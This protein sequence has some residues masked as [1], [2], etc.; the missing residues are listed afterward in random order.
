MTPKIRVAAP[1]LTLVRAVEDAQALLA[2]FADRARN[3]SG[4]SDP[5]P[6]LLAQCAQLY[7]DTRAATEPYRTLLYD[8]PGMLGPLAEVLHRAPNLIILANGSTA[9]TP[10]LV[11]ADRIMGL[12]LTHQLDRHNESIDLAVVLTAFTA[13]IT[14]L[15]DGLTRTGQRLVVLRPVAL[16]QDADGSGPGP[17]APDLQPARTV[18]VL[19]HPA[20]SFEHAVEGTDLDAFCTRWHEYLDSNRHIITLRHEILLQ[21]P[22]RFAAS[23]GQGLDLA[24]PNGPSVSAPSSNAKTPFPEAS[25]LSPDDQ[26]LPS[27]VELCARLGYAASP[28]RS[29]AAAG[30]PAPDS[31]KPYHRAILVVG[32]PRTGT[33]FAASLLTALGLEVGHERDGK[34]GISSWMFAVE[35][36]KNPY[37]I[38]PVAASRR[39]L[40]WDHLLHPV[41]DVA[42][43][44]PSI[45][46]EN[47]YAP[48]SL[49]FRRY[50]ILRETG[51]DLDLQVDGFA[52]AVLSLLEWSRIIDRLAPGLVFR[53]EDQQDR[54]LTYLRNHELISGIAMPAPA[55]IKTND[56]KAYQGFHYP[57]PAIG[58]ADWAKLDPPTWLGVV[59]Y[60]QRYGYDL[61]SRDEA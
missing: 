18:L 60:C 47:A 10:G 42:T 21:A 36:A 1:P 6:G 19:R 2:E 38:D 24:F 20:S 44:V 7:K 58:A 30:F 39:N 26:S 37:A 17:P 46:R 50:H 45:M 35:D 28:D 40:H 9:K 49:A 23:L 33:A 11:A 43:A 52:K 55:A 3:Q 41:R 14:L 53:I 32:H 29:A 25:R 12:D 22:V 15:Q 27:Y 57:K 4:G 48:L 8:D 61:P 54:L 16:P 5:L 51:T 34:D 56:D 59:T 31:A 13:M